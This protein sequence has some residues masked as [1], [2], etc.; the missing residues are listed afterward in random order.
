[1]QAGSAVH[2]NR[3][4]C[5]GCMLACT[6]LSA[7]AQ[8]ES[9][10]L[11]TLAKVE[12]T[13]SNIA[14]VEGESGLPVQVITREELQQGGMQTVQDLLERIS[15]NQSFG[16]SNPALGVNNLAGRVHRRVAA[17]PRQRAH[18]G[19][20]Q[21]AAPCTLC[22]F[23][24]PERRSVGHSRV[25]DRARRDPQGRGFGHLWHRRH[26]RR[27]EL[28]PAQ[29]FPGRRTRRQRLSH[30]AGRRQQWACQPH[31]GQRRPGARTSTTS[32]SRR[33]TSSRM[34]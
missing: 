14:R 5:A 27:H 33:A 10:P 23:G 15:A 17:R 9:A 13:G 4:V 31:R 19:A 32:S 12:V 26:R 2:R 22:A 3:Q 28:H 8:S 30:A 16:G 1:M 6:G 29:G 11:E 24:R 7:G 34:R 20:A 18:A 21:W 25:G